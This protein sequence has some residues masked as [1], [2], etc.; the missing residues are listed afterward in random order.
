MKRKQLK[1]Y[2]AQLEGVAKQGREVRQIY[3][4][5]SVVPKV[6]HVAKPQLVTSSVPKVVYKVQLV[7]LKLHGYGFQ[8]GRP[9]AV[10][11]SYWK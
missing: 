11:S 6:T 10:P 2:E 1:Q 5:T 3:Q 9:K 7:S 4:G 8:A